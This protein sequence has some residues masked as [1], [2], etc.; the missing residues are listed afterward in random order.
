MSYENLTELQ[1]IALKGEL[2]AI[3]S[4][5][6]SDEDLKLKIYR[7]LKESDEQYKPLFLEAIKESV[8]LN[9]EEIM[10]LFFMG[11]MGEIP[12]S[13]WIEKT[14]EDIKYY[15]NAPDLSYKNF[16]LALNKKE[17]RRN[18]ITSAFITFARKTIMTSPSA[19]LQ[20]INKIFED[21]ELE[22]LHTSCIYLQGGCTDVKNFKCCSDEI[23]ES[24]L[25]C[26]LDPHDIMSL[27]IE[28]ECLNKIDK[29]S[30]YKETP[31]APENEKIVAVS[32][33]IV[34]DTDKQ[35]LSPEE[36]SQFLG[37]QVMELFNS[38]YPIEVEEPKNSES[39]LSYVV[40]KEFNNTDIKTDIRKCDSEK[41]ALEFIEEIKKA[42]PE[43]QRTCKFVI[44]KKIIEN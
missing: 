7:I 22:F 28:T 29:D 6:H 43:L 25:K 14:I 32:K 4:F 38:I 24:I 23:S 3:F 15:L 13:L 41:E 36:L 8:S 16:K 5:A 42:Y 11:S 21:N 19:V 39:K 1:K 40:Q 10:R 18:I 35:K 34:I 44:C 31:K 26:E 17:E 30:L 9:E 2:S 27:G 20:L 37:K 12:L 33:G